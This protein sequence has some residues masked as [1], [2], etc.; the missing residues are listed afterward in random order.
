MGPGRTKPNNHRVPRIPMLRLQTQ[1]TPTHL[2]IT[3]MGL[4]VLKVDFH[5]AAAEAPVVQEP[6]TIDG[7]EAVDLVA[8]VA[9]LVPGLGATAP[10]KTSTTSPT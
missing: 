6:V 2:I 9:H 1:S 7:E 8:A 10:R 3:T 5:S 4:L